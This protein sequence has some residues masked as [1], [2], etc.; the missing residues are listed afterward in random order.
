VTE[1]RAVYLD[2]SAL[3]RR[4]EADVPS[5]TQRN[6]LAGADVASVL[7]LGTA[8]LATCE[9]GL[10]EFHN[11]VTGLWRDTDANNSQ[12][13]AAWLERALTV[14]MEDIAT[15]RLVV[16]PVPPRAFEHGM[17]MV[18]M[19]ARKT[20]GRKLKV[21][22]AVHLASAM[23][24]ATELGHRIELWTSDNHF[25]GFLTSYPGFARWV[26]IRNLNPP[27]GI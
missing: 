18:T 3:M 6:K 10:L 7:S 9:V 24:W 14:T 8:T 26:T 1:E 2:T 20:E 25:D 15:G 5:P 27:S 13:D 11:S 16:R 19:A 12:Y 21:W 4:C 17:T 23:A 22:D